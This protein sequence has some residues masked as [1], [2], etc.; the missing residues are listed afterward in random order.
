MQEWRRIRNPES[1]SDDVYLAVRGLYRSSGGGLR[2]I[3][4]KHRTHDIFYVVPCSGSHQM[5]R[6]GPIHSLKEAKSY[7]IDLI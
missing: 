4:L 1:E 6:V 2:G 7:L 5:E 3:I